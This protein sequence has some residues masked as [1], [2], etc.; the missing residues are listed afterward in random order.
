MGGGRTEG[1]VGAGSGSQVETVGD[2][3]EGC[4]LPGGERIWRDNNKRGEMGTKGAM[5]GRGRAC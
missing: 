2:S 4:T 3:V 1:Q 5:D